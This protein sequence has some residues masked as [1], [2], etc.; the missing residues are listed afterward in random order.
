MPKLIYL[1]LLLPLASLADDTPASLRLCHDD[2]DLAPWVLRDG[3]GLS[4]QLIAKTAHEFKSM[5]VEILPLAWTR[6]LKLLESGQVDGAFGTSYLAERETFA[7]YPKK[8]DGSVDST[9]RLNSVSYSLYVRQESRLQWD[10][11]NFT[12][13]GATIGIQNGFSIG[14][15]LQQRGAMPKPLARDT[16]ELLRHLAARHVDAAAPQTTQADL[17]LKQD[18]A[19][20]QQIR[21]LPVTLTEKHYYLVFSRSF[22]QQHPGFAR[23]F[24]QHLQHL[25]DK[26][27]PA[28]SDKLANE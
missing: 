27:N 9:L 16:R 3:Q 10:G 4:Q 26:S 7:V 12:P 25:R 21:K 23:Q 5:E 1:L 20:A 8:N 2:V 13:S 15:L 19:L 6:C 22:D 18:P 11:K 28:R 14:K 24:W 17:E